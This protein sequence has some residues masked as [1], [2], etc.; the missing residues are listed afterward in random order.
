MQVLQ[1]QA[2]SKALALSWTHSVTLNNFTSGK[3]RRE[4]SLPWQV[5]VLVLVL[6]FAFVDSVSH[7]WFPASPQHYRL[8]AFL[9]P[10]DWRPMTISFIFLSLFLNE[11][12]SVMACFF[13]EDLTCTRRFLEV[14]CGMH[15]MFRGK[16]EVWTIHFLIR[17]I[18]HYSYVNSACNVIAYTEKCRNI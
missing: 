8:A 16:T 12:V 17:C 14:F 9:L 2:G 10:Q 18:L 11:D 7:S 13:T 3:S 4:F 15:C 1:L 5:W 6:S